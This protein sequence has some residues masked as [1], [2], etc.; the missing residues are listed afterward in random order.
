M[1]K[2]SYYLVVILLIIS[3]NLNAQELKSTEISFSFGVNSLAVGKDLGLNLEGTLGYSINSDVTLNFSF[4][5]ASMK[6][7]DLELNY[8]LNRFAFL[9]NYDFAEFKTSKCESILGLSYLNFDKKIPLDEN[10]GL[11]LDL[12]I[13]ITFYTQSKL[14]YGFRV[15]STY[16]SSSPGTILNSGIFLKYRF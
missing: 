4:S 5:D 3:K 9:F 2:L 13:Q 12:G 14:N 8:R 1:K 7:K 15:V 10:S 11:G 16:F 6:S